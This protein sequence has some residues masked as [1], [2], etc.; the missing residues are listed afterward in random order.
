MVPSVT[1]KASI[2]PR[3]ETR[4]L[5]RPAAMPRSSPTAMPRRMV[6]QPVPVVG[7]SRFMMMII[8]PAIQAAIEPTERSMPP[9]MMTSVAPT[10]MIPINAVRVK[11]LVRL[12]T[13]RNVG[14]MAAPRAIKAMSAI[15]GPSAVNRP[16]IRWAVRGVSWAIGVDLTVYAAPFTP[17]A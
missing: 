13:E 16:H 8:D 4:P 11:T 1:M 10:A 7:T 12:A 17:V 5:T 9:A 15:N 2:F 14:L 3:V 6:V